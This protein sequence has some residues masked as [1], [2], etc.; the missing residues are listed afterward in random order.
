LE[1]IIS[2]IAG[3]IGYLVATFWFR[4]ILRYFDLKHK[5]VVDLVV[6]AN[7]INPSGDDESI[8]S[9]HEKRV[10]ALRNHSAEFLA[11]FEDL[12]SWF[13]WVLQ[14]RSENPRNASG[15]LMGLSNT[16]DYDQTRARIESIKKHLKF[17][18]Q[19]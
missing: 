4:P 14:K 3:A 10:L 12:P 11:C 15:N 1:V 8:Q 6:Y 19:L 16:R 7:A 2:V 9:L 5:L 17:E 13:Q 18:W